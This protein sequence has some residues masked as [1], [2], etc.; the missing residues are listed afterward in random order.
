MTLKRLHRPLNTISPRLN[1]AQPAIPTQNRWGSGRGGRPW[2]RKREAIALR[3]QYLCQIHLKQGKEVVI[4]LSQGIC[5]HIIPTA[6]GGS[7]DPDN[8]QWIC[9]ECST[10]KTQQESQRGKGNH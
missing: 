2:R 10:A 3:D 5:D 9:N 8:L 7:D 1:Q 4:D 6:E